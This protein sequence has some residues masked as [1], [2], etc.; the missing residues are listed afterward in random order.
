MSPASGDRMSFWGSPR[1]IVL[2]AVIAVIALYVWLEHR[3]HVLA[4]LPFL[5]PL[6]ICLGMHFFMHR[7]HGGNHG[8]HAGH[9][10]HK[11]AERG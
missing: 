7:N 4:V 9:H 10:E 8:R 1:G 6:V 3:V 11:D 2:S 5:L